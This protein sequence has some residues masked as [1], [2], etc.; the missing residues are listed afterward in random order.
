LPFKLCGSSRK[1]TA[2][3]PK[4]EILRYLSA[5]EVMVFLRAQAGGVLQTS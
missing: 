1:K 5:L 3:F 4:A 2:E